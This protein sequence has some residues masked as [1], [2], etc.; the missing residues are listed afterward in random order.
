MKY[1]I[2]FEIKYGDLSQ[3]EIRDHK[4]GLLD[5][6]ITTEIESEY[7]LNIPCKDEMVELGEE[8]YSINAIY[9]KIEKDCY[10]SVISVISNKIKNMLDTKQRKLEAEL[11]MKRM[12]SMLGYRIPIENEFEF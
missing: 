9:H 7:P 12:A 2:K 4:L 10:T 6:D 8:L 1:K 5:Q 3:D 11:E